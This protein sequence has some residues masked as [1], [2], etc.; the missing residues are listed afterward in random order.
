MLHQF[1]NNP[2][3]LLHKLTE[4]ELAP[5]W[6]EVNRYPESGSAPAL[7]T[8][9]DQRD[10]YLKDSHEYIQQLVGP[11]VGAFVEGFGYG[12]HLDRVDCGQSLALNRA[13]VTFQRQGDFNPVHTHRGQVSFVIWL[14]IPYTFAD[15]QAHAQRSQLGLNNRHVNG[16]FHFQWPDTTGLTREHAMGADQQ[17]EGHIC[18]F[19]SNLQHQVYPFWSTDHIRITVSG[20][21]G[22]A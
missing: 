7:H 14:R 4:A 15:E 10:L 13:W 12:L 21:W 1:P 22:V 16:D 11:Y 8:D 5:I 17:L 18:V 3:Y 6:A 9:A 2:G 19:S 20:N